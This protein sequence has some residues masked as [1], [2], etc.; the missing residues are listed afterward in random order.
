MN[1]RF[2]VAVLLL[3]SLALAQEKMYQ[4]PESQ[5]TEQ[6]KAKFQGASPKDVRDWVGLGKEIGM[7]VNESLSA[8]TVQSNNF[9]QTPVGKLTVAVVIFKVI[10]DPAI[11]LL[12]G[13][14]EALVL[15]PLWIWSYRKFLPRRVV[16]SQEYGEN[17]KKKLVVYED[18][19]IKDDEEWRGGHWAALFLLA[20]IILSTIFSY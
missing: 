7:A 12:V 19:E 2:T 4:V 5:L 8:I 13:T 9:A 20:I 6:Q 16:K 1:R 18:L 17:G 3:S 14:V 10:G 15:I 11:H